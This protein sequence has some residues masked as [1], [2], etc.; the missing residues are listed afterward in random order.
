MPKSSL[1]LCSA[2]TLLF[3][4]QAAS[5]LFK[6]THRLHQMESVSLKCFCISS[7]SSFPLCS[8][9][10]QTIFH[11]LALDLPAPSLQIFSKSQLPPHA[12]QEGA[13]GGV[14][15]TAW[16][17]CLRQGHETWALPTELNKE[18]CNLLFVWSWKAPAP[19]AH[20]AWEPPLWGIQTGSSNQAQ[21][22]GASPAEQETQFIEAPLSSIGEVNIWVCSKSKGLKA[23]GNKAPH[24]H[25]SPAGWVP[26]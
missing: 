11:A 17:R 12:P 3:P 1:V 24:L 26:A 23:L 21:G 16:Q 20:P 8:I 18:W 10:G 22:R 9:P 2:L 13:Q 25:L 6:T 15:D 4:L 5:L 19:C 7:K 14:L